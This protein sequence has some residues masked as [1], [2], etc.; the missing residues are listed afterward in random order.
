MLKSV[1]TASSTSTKQIAVRPTAVNTTMYTVP[2]GKTFTGYAVCTAGNGCDL[3]INGV[4]IFQ[5]GGSTPYFAT[6]FPL[7]CPAGTVISCGSSY[8]NWTI[9][10]TEQ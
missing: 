8:A 4:S 10:G 5:M 7:N 3:V 1:N 6:P 2:S 9:Y